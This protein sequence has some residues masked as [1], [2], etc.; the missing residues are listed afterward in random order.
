MGYQIIK[1]LLL[2]FVFSLASCKENKSLVDEDFGVETFYMFDTCVTPLSSGVICRY[3]LLQYQSP[4]FLLDYLD[5]IVTQEM[6]CPCY[7]NTSTG[8]EV[9]FRKDEDG[10]AIVVFRP[11]RKLYI[12]D[13]SKYDGYFV[14]N[15]HYFLCYGSPEQFS[16]KEM[17]KKVFYSYKPIE[18]SEIGYLGYS[19]WAFDFTDSIILDSKIICH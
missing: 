5:S 19:M 1:L 14:F 6:K 15:N 10:Y 8:F 7:R 11:L 3:E 2:I 9:F 17:E 16:L 13:Y 12:G 4:D 18:I